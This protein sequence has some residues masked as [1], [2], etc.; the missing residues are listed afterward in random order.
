MARR[1]P[2]AARVL[3]DIG[4]AQRL[5]VFDQRAEHPPAARQLADRA[6]GLRVDPH[7]QELLKLRALVVEDPDR[8]VARP[9]YLPC[10]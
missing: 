2:V 7:D 9:G 8:G 4:Q 3:A 5:G 1:E 6:A 10:R